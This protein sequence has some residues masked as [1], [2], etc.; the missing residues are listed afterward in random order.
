MIMIIEDNDYNVVIS[1]SKS[2]GCIA[3]LATYRGRNRVPPPW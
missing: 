1:V 3:C 2:L